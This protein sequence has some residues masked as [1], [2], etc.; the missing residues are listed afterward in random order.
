MPSAPR[1]T[2]E[3]RG[4]STPHLRLPLDPCP[5]PSRAA[6]TTARQDLAT[7][8]AAALASTPRG[9][10]AEAPKSSGMFGM[11]GS[12]RQSHGAI[13][14]TLVSLDPSQQMDDDGGDE[15]DAA[16]QAAAAAAR[17]CRHRYRHRRVRLRRLRLRP[18]APGPSPK[19]ASTTPEPSAVP[20]ARRRSLWPSRSGPCTRTP[21]SSATG[22]HGR[23]AA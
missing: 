23:A 22:R 8:L 2:A 19:A 4:A 16:P 12:K 14:N 5:S 21:T 3:R 7:R 17:C 11:G 20:A 18:R 9:G 15:W 13:D 1:L 6:T 10:K